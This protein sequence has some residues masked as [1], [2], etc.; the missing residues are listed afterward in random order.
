[1]TRLATFRRLEPVAQCDILGPVARC[2]LKD[3]DAQLSV[4]NMRVIALLSLSVPTSCLDNGLAVTP[5]MGWRSWNQM[6]LNI[7]Q[8]YVELVFQA[9]ADRSR[10]VDGSYTSLADLG[11]TRAGIDDGWQL[12]NSGPDGK[13]FHNSSGYPIVDTAKFPNMMAMTEHARALGIHPGW[14]QGNCHCADHRCSGDECYSGDVKATLDFGFD[15][16]KIDSC[17]S[18]RNVG[19]MSQLFNST[20]NAILIENC[21]NGVPKRTSSGVQCPMNLFRSSVDIRPTFGSILKNLNSVAKFNEA[22]LTG[23]G[24]W[25]YPDMLEVGV[26]APQPP[27]AKHHC[28]S[29][30]DPCQMN[31]TEWRT[32]F[33]AWCIVSA[34]LILGMDLTDHVSLDLAWPILT[35]VEAIQVNQ[36]WAGDSG[37]LHAK[38]T[39]QTQLPNCG[40]GSGCLQTS[41]MVWTKALADKVDGVGRRAAVLLMNNGNATSVV[42]VDLGSV[43]GLEKCAGAYA[44]RDL[45]TKSDL[46][47]LARNLSAVLEPH[48]S[49]FYV[50][51]CTDPVPSPAPTPSP[52]PMPVPA[53]SCLSDGIRFD[54]QRSGNTNLINNYRHASSAQACQDICNKEAGC[55]CF[56]HRLSTGHCWLMTSCQTPESDNRYVSGPA[57]CPHKAGNAHG[58]FV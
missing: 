42:S 3:F 18:D 20:D 41:W 30:S 7:N 6:G 25:A 52:A 56:T 40:S 16:I 47:L 12:C 33:S 44:V 11:Y 39:E 35:N 53:L 50:V 17:S 31:V 5:P 4:K 57:V 54:S 19:K 21:H 8:S 22:N 26:T 37:R 46:L 45:W 13:G 27:G 48:D 55:E 2:C 14:Y 10:T 32:H 43:H 1:V 58:T 49:G 24:C 28:Q 36:L 23:P 51:S 34:P 9:L 15:S 29:E 38:S